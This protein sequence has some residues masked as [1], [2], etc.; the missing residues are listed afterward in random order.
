MYSLHPQTNFWLPSEAARQEQR[1]T[2]TD[3]RIDEANA[4]MDRATL[5]DC[6]TSDREALLS[7]TSALLRHALMYTPALALAYERLGLL[8]RRGR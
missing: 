6:S 4:L 5:M 8:E 2:D 1:R 3:A 7:D